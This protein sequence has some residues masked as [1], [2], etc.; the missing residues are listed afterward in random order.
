MEKGILGDE[1]ADNPIR[2]TAVM[3]ANSELQHIPAK[4][5]PA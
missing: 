3:P 2:N 1:T 5:D 4:N